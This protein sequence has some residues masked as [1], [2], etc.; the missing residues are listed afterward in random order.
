VSSYVPVALRRAVAARAGFACEYCRIREA[1]TFFGCEVEHVIAEKHGGPTA[2][3]N[4]AYACLPCNRHKGT[5]IASIAPSTSRLTRLFNPRSDRW[6]D[7]FELV[8]V[9]VV[10]LTEIGEVTVRVL[11]LNHPDRL[12]EREPLIDAGT[13]PAPDA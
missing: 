11:S 3:Q 7:H 6:D 2:E 13:Y 10:P 4:L 12:V 8:G 5:D 1:D 9:E